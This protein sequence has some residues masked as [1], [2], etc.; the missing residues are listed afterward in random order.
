MEK[1]DDSSV[2]SSSLNAVP[3]SE[4]IHISLFGR[5]NAGKSSLMNC[6]T[7]QQMAVVSSTPGT[8]T[9][10]VVKAMELLPLGPVVLTDTPGIDD[11]GD[12]GSLRV[13]KAL[14][15]L[16]KTDI[17]LLVADA[18]QKLTGYELSLL[19]EF[20]KRRLPHM[21][22]WNK[23]DLTEEIPALP[24]LF[25]AVPSIFVSAAAGRNIEQLKEA[26]AALLPKETPK[27]IVRDLI[28]TN[29]FVVLVVPIDKAAPKGRL[30]LPQQQTIRDLL[31]VGAVSLTVRDT[32]L[33]HALKM[34]PF[35]PALVITDS[36]VFS[37][38]SRIVPEDVPLTS[39]SI[40]FARYKGDLD[41]LVGGA[42]HIDL[43]Q[44]NSRVLI[45]EGCTHHRQC[46][47]IGTVKLPGW[48]AKHTGKNLDLTFTSGGEFP[49]DLSSFDLIIHCGGCMLNEKEM[50]HR[51][52]SAKRQ[53]IPVTNYGTAIA[54]MN[55][56]LD[57]SLQIFTSRSE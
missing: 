5:R 21:I 6:L 12:L 48:L 37:K 43:L 1:R 46:E 16:R 17:A 49:E 36:Q 32:E 13:Q 19:D 8:T 9:D 38:I 31:D 11:V 15:S 57:R 4:R 42:R 18:S 10:P 28:Q 22:V 34:L 52:A 33:D 56:I 14:A 39:F 7:N 29:D 44:E 24:D 51:L 54:Y 40:L 53:G 30:I 25:S 23:C 50:H 45:S 27:Y 20:K 47:D 2:N 26:I 3:S 41:T 35:P 55:G